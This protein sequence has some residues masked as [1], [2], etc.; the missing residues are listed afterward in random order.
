MIECDYVVVGAGPWVNRLWNM[1][2]LPR[3]HRR[4]RAATARCMTACRPGLLVRCRKAR[5]AS[6]RACT[7]PMTATC[8]RSSTSIPTRRSI[9]MSTARLITDQL[10]GIYYKPDFN[11]G[12]VQGG[13]SPYIVEG[14]TRRGRDRSVRSGLAGFRR[15]RPT[16]SRCGARRWRI[17]RSASKARSTNTRSTSRPA[18]SAASR[19]TASR[20]STS[21]RENVFVIADSNHGY[22][23]IGVGKLVARKFA[24]K[25]RAARAVPVFAIRRRQAAPD[26]Q[27]SVSVE[28]IR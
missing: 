15:R 10:W 28:L 19:R 3:D 11:F 17:A 23:M 4:S 16:S 9:P 12:G 5:S 14:R 24:A 2:E 1:L 18:A 25:S 27:Q 20:C 13:A 22:K 26:F 21:F 8:R 7:R 6:I